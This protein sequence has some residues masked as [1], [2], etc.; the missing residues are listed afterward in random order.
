MLFR[1]ERRLAVRF[2]SL[3]GE[4][5]Q[6]AEVVLD[7]GPGRDDATGLLASLERGQRILNATGLRP[8]SMPVSP[9]KLL[10]MIMDR[11]GIQA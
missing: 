11:D 3:L 6:A 7:L 9:R 8:T 5:P 1:S 4:F 10:E 2:Q